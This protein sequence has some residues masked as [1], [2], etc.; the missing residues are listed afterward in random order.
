MVELSC[1]EMQHVS[2]AVGCSRYSH[3]ESAHV[4]YIR[5]P[6]C[7]LILALSPSNTD[8]PVPYI[9]QGAQL[10]LEDAG[11]IITLLEKLCFEDDGNGGRF[12]LA[13]F[14]PAMAVYEKM[15][16]PRVRE[17]LEISRRWGMQQQ[18]RSMNEKYNEVKETL[19][20]RDV[21]FY[22]TMKDILPGS[23]YNYLEQIEAAL[24]KEPVLL[25]RIE[26]ES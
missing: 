13:N 12:N 8:P 19:I 20:Q 4:A 11:V 21:F 24:Q 23:T 25:A 18:K 26:E 6:D 10:G 5:S 1:L 22:E 9:G 15:R 16:L 7:C 2:V 3:G 14:G 17:I